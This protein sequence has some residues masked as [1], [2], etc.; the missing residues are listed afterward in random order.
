MTPDDERSYFAEAVDKNLIT[1]ELVQYL[2]E[3]RARETWEISAFVEYFALQRFPA[4]QIFDER[5]LSDGVPEGWPGRLLD[6]F[7]SGSGLTIYLYQYAIII[8]TGDAAFSEYSNYTRLLVTLYELY[9]IHLPKEI[10]RREWGTLAFYGAHERLENVAWAIGRMQGMPVRPTPP[11]E[12]AATLYVRLVNL[13][14]GT[15]W[16]EAMISRPEP[17]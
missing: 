4:L 2:E 1:P 17:G 10:A 3:G 5:V 9:Q 13:Q 7:R 6:F 11:S 14:P 8:G 15:A 16:M 12:D